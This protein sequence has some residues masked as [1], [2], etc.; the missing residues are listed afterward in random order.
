[1][2][3]AKRLRFFIP[4]LMSWQEVGWAEKSFFADERGT[5]LRRMK[6]DNLLFTWAGL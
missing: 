2:N 3:N 5:G 6:N 1:L 4:V